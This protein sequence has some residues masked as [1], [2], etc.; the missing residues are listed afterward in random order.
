MDNNRVVCVVPVYNESD[1]IKETI[2]KLDTIRLIDEIVIV[3]DGSEDNSLDVLEKLG[4]RVISYEK[5]MGKGYA[6]K[7]AMEELDY[8]YLMLVDGDLGR[9]SGEVYRLLD[10]ILRSEADFTVARFPEAKKVT[11]KKGGFGLVKKLAKNGVRFFTGQ[12]IESSLSGQ[13]VY[14]KEVLDS[15]DY[16]PNR[17]GIEVAMTVQAL[18]NGFEIL[19][20]PVEMTHRYTGRDMA[21]FIHRG[22][23]FKDILKTFIVMFFK[24]YKR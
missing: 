11:K 14:K 18:N 5:N 12:E 20:V 3:N 17:Y 13:R 22:K 19:E 10:P 8:G 24:G 9:S 6:I 1:V 21:G 7:R 16:I 15:I 4:K 2:K 23:Q